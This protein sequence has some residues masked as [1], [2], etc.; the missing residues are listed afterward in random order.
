[1]K[2]TPEIQVLPAIEQHFALRLA[3]CYGL[4]E[5][6]NRCMLHALID[7]PEYIAAHAVVMAGCI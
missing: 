4:L 7:A 1:M 6:W 5:V 3:L 2:H